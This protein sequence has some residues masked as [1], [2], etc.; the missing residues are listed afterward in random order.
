MHNKRPSSYQPVIGFNFW[1]WTVVFIISFLNRNN[2]YFILFKI[3]ITPDRIQ[4]FVHDLYVLSHVG[5]LLLVYKKLLFLNLLLRVL[6]VVRLDSDYFVFRNI[7][8]VLRR[9]FSFRLCSIVYFSKLMQIIF[10]MP[11]YRINYW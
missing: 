3:Y 2:Y 6:C 11:T 4:I 1:Y 7:T 8:Y 9:V 5:S 10:I